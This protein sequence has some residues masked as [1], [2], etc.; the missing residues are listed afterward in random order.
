MTFVSHTHDMFSALDICICSTM[1]YPMCLLCSIV[2][3]SRQVSGT[4]D[5][6]L[7]PPKSG[8][9]S[10]KS[11]NQYMFKKSK[12]KKIGA[13]R[14]SLQSSTPLRNL[15]IIESRKP[16]ASAQ[17]FTVRLQTVPRTRFQK[18]QQAL[19]NDC[20]CLVA[21]EVDQAFLTTRADTGGARGGPAER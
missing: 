12:K 10:L 17:T 20:A 4:L 16:Q 15:A 3:C 11:Q 18:S 7:S 21:L 8:T 19:S 9:P 5:T 1:I 13:L 6:N 2:C 14:S